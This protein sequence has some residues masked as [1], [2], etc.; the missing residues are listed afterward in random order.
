M[1]NSRIRFFLLFLILSGGFLFSQSEPVL[2]IGEWGTGPYLD[3]FVQGNRA[4]CAAES[5]GL[6]IID[7]STPATPVKLS[8]LE[9]TGKAET[10]FVAGN[11]AYVCGEGNFYVVDVSD[12]FDPVL[13]NTID[14]L[15]E[16]LD[17]FVQSDF[18]YIADGANGLQIINI[19]NPLLPTIS[20]GWITS[21]IAEDIFVQGDYAYLAVNNGG[22]LIV[23]VT[24]PS[25]PEPKNTYLTPYP[26]TQVYVI[27]SRA[28]IAYF[29]FQYFFGFDI[30]DISDPLSPTKLGSYTEDSSYIWNYG[31]SEIGGLTVNN[32][33]AY[34]LIRYYSNFPMS[35]D[36]Y[37]SS[38]RYVDVSD[39][40]QDL[41][42]HGCYNNRS[43]DLFLADDFIY[44]AGYDNGLSIHDQVTLNRV[45]GGYDN[46]GFPSE[47]NGIAVKDNKLFI[48]GF[49]DM[50]IIDVALPSQPKLLSCYE[51]DYFETGIFLK[52]NLT[53]Q[54]ANRYLSGPGGGYTYSLEAL[55]IS[56]VYSPTLVGGIGRGNSPTGGGNGSYI[57]ND[58]AYIT[59]WLG[60]L[61]LFNISTPETIAELGFYSG[62]TGE[63]EVSDNY[64]Y[65]AQG[66]D[67]LQI[68]NISDKEVLTLAGSY[69]TPGNAADLFIDGNYIYIAD[70]PS[71]LLVLDLTDPVVP[72]FAS[73]VATSGETTGIYVEND[74]AYVTDTIDGLLVFDIS[75]PASL[76]PAGSFSSFCS[77][78]QDVLVEG[79]YIYVIAGKLYILFQ[80]SDLPP[81]I[82]ITSPRSRAT[83]LGTASVV[84]DATDDNGITKVYFYIN[85]SMV[86][87]DYSFPYDYS[88]NTT[89][90]PDGEHKVK[91]MVYDTAA[92][93]SYDEVVVNVNYTNP[94][95]IELS[96]TDL[97]FCTELNGATTSDQEFL[98]SNP[99]AGS[100]NWTVDPVKSWII[101]T[102]S[103]GVG[104]GAV[105]ISVSPTGL[106]PGHYSS[107]VLIS[108]IE[109]V[110]SPRLI[111]VN[112]NVLTAG[113][114]S[115]PIGYWDTPTD[116]ATHVRGSIP[117]SGWAL[118]DIEVTRVEIKRRPEP[119]DPLEAIGSD[120]L[121]YIGDAL[122]VEGSRPD[123][124][125]TPP[126]N[127]YPCNYRAGWGYMLLTY[128]LP[129]K[130]NGTYVLHAFIWDIEGKKTDL[131]TKTITCDNANAVKTFWD[132]GY[133]RFGYGF[134]RRCLW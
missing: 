10:L 4:Y 27:G 38:I 103:V 25:D 61:R 1:D 23:D 35:G 116:G 109:A 134:S 121:V 37:R 106:A 111:N 95:L 68:I 21:D 86:D 110:N 49:K 77:P 53:F 101:V 66:Q 31:P 46:S 119:E 55:N 78:P 128:G 24:D 32:D 43:K 47:I 89:I 34:F 28:Y 92:Q 36:S 30:L 41:R 100:I 6:D 82:S 59:N 117:L 97:Y 91:A 105:S 76:T 26:A 65:I 85:D 14:T 114:A 11:Y 42:Y 7:I 130:G 20:G 70:G 81:A 56:D 58:Y 12:P 52:D 112:L 123:L 99:G 75:S 84:A 93:L 115:P 40:S 108:S 57:H 60:N 18:A 120:G 54:T 107:S 69:D 72:T 39:P 87:E 45:E 132:S 125:T 133:T 90:Y 118:D 83:V 8:N 98:I 19:S 9:F 16:T 79:H 48:N 131:G 113:T 44:I 51:S 129:R 124:E 17:V 104:D 22:L 67:G 122:F 73:S 80:G 102:P 96:K 29:E 15:Q 64:A 63:I 5:C 50:Q 2:K 126:Y 127:L 74:L 13:E 33:N 94:P 71:G 62:M 3:V 88:W